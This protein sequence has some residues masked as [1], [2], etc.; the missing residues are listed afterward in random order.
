MYYP[1]NIDDDPGYIF[2]QAVRKWVRGNRKEL[3]AKVRAACHNSK[4]RSNYVRVYVYFSV[5]E[6]KL[7]FK[8]VDYKMDPNTIDTVYSGPVV[9]EDKAEV[10]FDTSDN[11]FG[12]IA[13][14]I[15]T[16]MRNEIEGFSLIDVPMLIMRVKK[17]KRQDSINWSYA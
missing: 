3:E 12:K 16:M 6:I 7:L 14:E 1:M 15:Y 17:G 2:R 8:V 11:I 10:H 13:L 9:Y 5:N 4:V